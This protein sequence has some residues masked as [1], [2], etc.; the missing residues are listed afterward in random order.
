M[1]PLVPILSALPVSGTFDGELVALGEDGSPDFPLLCER[2]LS[3]Q[4]EALNLNGIYWQTPETFDD[5]NALF[6]TVCA[7]MS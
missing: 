3:A 4:L 2:M 1:T 5:G 7:R 6:D